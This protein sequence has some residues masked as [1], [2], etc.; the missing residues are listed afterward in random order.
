M[1]CKNK[2]LK[3]KIFFCNSGKRRALWG[4]R[5]FSDPFPP[6]QDDSQFSS[7]LTDDFLINV[8]GTVC[9]CRPSIRRTGFKLIGP[10]LCLRSKQLKRLFSYHFIGHRHSYFAYVSRSTNKQPTNYCPRPMLKMFGITNT[11]N[12]NCKLKIESIF[13]IHKVKIEKKKWLFLPFFKNNNFHYFILY[14]KN[15]CWI[16]LFF[17]KNKNEFEAF[18]WK[19]KM[20]CVHCIS[21]YIDGIGRVLELNQATVRRQLTI[22]RIKTSLSIDVIVIATSLSSHTTPTVH[23][24]HR[25]RVPP[26]FI[27]TYKK[28]FTM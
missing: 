15:L 4:C 3:E 13:F 20:Y 5:S 18:D 28:A 16:W 1:E 26:M 21:G 22:V 9:F 11:L 8:F 2:S 27:R 6:G 23:G 14:L 10:P 7:S 19:K 17:L 25:T 24:T 12:I